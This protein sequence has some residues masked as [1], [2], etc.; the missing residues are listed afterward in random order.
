MLEMT[1][2]VLVAWNGTRILD[3][4][5]CDASLPVLTD[6]CS[7]WTKTFSCSIYVKHFLRRLKFSITK[8]IPKS[9]Q[10]YFCHC[11][12]L[13]PWK[14]V[15]LSFSIHRIKLTVCVHYLILSVYPA[16]IRLS[17]KGN[18]L[19][20]L[21]SPSPSVSLTT[22]HNLPVSEWRHV[23]AVRSLV[24]VFVCIFVSMHMPP[25]SAVF[26][27]VILL[28]FPLCLSAW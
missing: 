17:F 21:S 23:T 22:S 4:K 14:D 13:S 15:V 18:T 26:L 27:W 20:A 2:K 5:T 8:Q 12:D 1:Q 28:S 25:R 11:T 3:F 10:A 16:P 7:V 6:S 9:A 24:V 19:G